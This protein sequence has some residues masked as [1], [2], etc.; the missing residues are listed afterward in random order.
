MAMARCNVY[1]IQGPDPAKTA[2]V[3]RCVR[4]SAGKLKVDGKSYPVRKK[5]HGKD[6][7]LFKKGGW[8][9]VVDLDTKEK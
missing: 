7:N 6:W 4:D 1:V 2:S 9:Y 3:V 5:H 8:L